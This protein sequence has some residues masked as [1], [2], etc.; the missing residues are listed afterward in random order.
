MKSLMLTKDAFILSQIQY[1]QEYC[2]ILLQFEIA[3]FYFHIYSNK[4]YSCDAK[5]N[6]LH[7][8]S[9]VQCHM[10]FQK[11]FWCADLLIRLNGSVC[12]IAECKDVRACQNH[13]SQSGVPCVPRVTGGGLTGLLPEEV[14][15]LQQC[16]Q[17][18]PQGARVSYACMLHYVSFMYGETAQCRNNSIRSVF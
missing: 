2:E 17:K 4:M 15:C 13:V 10:I 11:S 14:E 8:Y 3:I 18:V 1:K 12:K 6:F 16:I 9:S 5:L 7:H